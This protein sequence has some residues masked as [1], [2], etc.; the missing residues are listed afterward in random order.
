M[1]ISHF[2][3]QTLQLNETTAE[4]DKLNTYYVTGDP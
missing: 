4:S 1:S 3:A 2:H